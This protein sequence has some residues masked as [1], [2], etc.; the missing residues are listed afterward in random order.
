MKAVIEKLKNNWGVTLFPEAT[1]TR[2]GKIAPL[3]AGFGLLAKRAQAPVV[4]M[5]IDGAF[6]AWP[7]HQSFFS[8]GGMIII[9]YGK[10]ISYEM[11]KDMDGRELASLLTEDLRKMQN[12]SRSKHGKETY[13]Y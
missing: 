5:V 1:R 11:I 6:E 9:N 4:P 3:R 7:R 13:K 2:D 12:E 8:T 10:P